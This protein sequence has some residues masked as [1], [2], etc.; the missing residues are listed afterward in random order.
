[1]TGQ[2]RYTGALA[3]AC[4]LLAAWPGPD[5]RAWARDRDLRARVPVVMERATVR[6]KVVVLESRRADRS[7]VEN[8][9]I[10]VWST[11]DG[12]SKKS[13]R[14]HETTTD[15]D[16]LFQLPLLEEGEYLFMIGELRLRLL[17]VPPAPEREGQEESKVLLIMMPKESI[18]I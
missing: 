13:A 9:G 7:A 6:G 14:L 4:L 18:S 8:L 2:Q 17:V 11:T 15:A 16:G 5:G 1:M 10:Q 12:G 3:A